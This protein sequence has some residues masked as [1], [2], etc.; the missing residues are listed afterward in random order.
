MKIVF[1]TAADNK[2]VDWDEYQQ[3]KLELENK[4]LTVGEMFYDAADGLY[5]GAH[6]IKRGFAEGFGTMW[7]N[8]RGKPVQE[9]QGGYYYDTLDTGGRKTYFDRDLH[10]SDL[11]YFAARSGMW[12]EFR[13]KSQRIARQAFDECKDYSCLVES[14]QFKK[15]SV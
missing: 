14:G 9:Q 15:L 10:E 13:E 1:N 11:A 7:N 3:K 2:I 4:Q 8:L 5:R 12:K 6:W